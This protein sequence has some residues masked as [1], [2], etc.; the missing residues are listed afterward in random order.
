MTAGLNDNSA[1]A[2]VSCWRAGVAAVDPRRA[3]PGALDDLASPAPR[4][5]IIAVGK[6][7][8]PMADAAIAWLRARGSDTAGGLIVAPGDDHHPVLPACV[9]DHPLP[10]PRSAAAA[11]A[12]GVLCESLPEGVPVWVMLSGGATSLI[13]GPEGG[14]TQTDLMESYRVLLASGWDIQRM[15]QVR[16]RLSRW[17]GGKLLRALGD[18]SVLQLVVSDVLDDDLA[19]I[20]SGPLV[21]DDHPVADVLAR[22]EADGLL[23]QLP[24]RAAALLRRIDAGTLPDVM[25]PGDPAAAR[26]STRV[27]VSNRVAVLAAAEAGRRLGWTVSVLE[28]PLRGEAADWG[29]RLAHAAMALPG[30]APTLIAAGGEPTVRLPPHHQGRGGRCQELAL[31]AAWALQAASGEILLL[32]AGTDGRDGPTDAAGALVTGKTWEGIGRSGLDPSDALARHDSYPALARAGALFHTGPTLTNV[33]DLVLCLRA[34]DQAR[35]TSAVRAG[36]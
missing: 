13:G 36:P 18:R 16:K 22:L 19:A 5:W 1:G 33:A 27:I 8:V 29:R 12:L 35:E 32:A 17:G 30:T 26:V 9:A 25:Q 11:A 34:G 21:P 3:V 7:A 24:S 15:N 14:L 23:P 10:G 28:S 20:G 2:L 6:A 31:A 4:P